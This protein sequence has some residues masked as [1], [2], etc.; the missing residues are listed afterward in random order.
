MEAGMSPA[1]GR[2]AISLIN[3]PT[4]GVVSYEG[5]AR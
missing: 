2:E 4:L 1:A 5:F 3:D